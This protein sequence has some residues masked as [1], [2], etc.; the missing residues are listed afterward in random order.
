MARYVALLRGINVGGKNLIRMADLKACFEAGGLQ[1]VATYI[2]SGNVFFDSGERSSTKL[3]RSIERMLTKTFGYQAMVV[4]RSK[5]QIRSVV[6]KAPKGFG[7]QPARYRS[8]VLF[9]KPPLT[10]AKTIGTIPT[11]EGVDQVHAGPGVLY[12][13][14]LAS[15]ASSSRLSKVASMPIYQSMTIRSWST[16]VKLRALMDGPQ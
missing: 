8:D 10:A 12:F 1:N 13:S 4:I 9:L 5:A 2:A 6:D 16:T 7:S 3:T 14:R 15:R 11:K